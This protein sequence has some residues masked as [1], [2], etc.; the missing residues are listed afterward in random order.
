MQV[1][2]WSAGG[3]G[4]L[5]ESTLEDLPAACAADEAC[6]GPALAQLR[7]DHTMLGDGTHPTA[8]GAA[9]TKSINI[10]YKCIS[11]LFEEP[12][13]V[14]QSIITGVFRRVNTIGQWHEALCFNR[15]R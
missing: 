5:R 12:F 10:T 4:Y 15:R 9:H 3:Q 11:G 7:V 13:N 2:G 6:S 8:A 1:C 14:H